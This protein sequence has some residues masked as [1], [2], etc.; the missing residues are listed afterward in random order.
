ML[1]TLIKQTI[2]IHNF[3]FDEKNINLI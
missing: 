2:F 3:N 1:V